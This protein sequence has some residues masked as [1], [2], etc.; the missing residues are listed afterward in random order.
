[1]IKATRSGNTREPQP[2]SKWQAPSGRRGMMWGPA[3]AVIVAVLIAAAL[4]VWAGRSD[5]AVDPG[6]NAQSCA[7]A[8]GCPAPGFRTAAEPVRQIPGTLRLAA[9]SG[10]AP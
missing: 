2:R 7:S 5:A 9:C 8:T 4:A 10:K 1:M 6:A 3:V